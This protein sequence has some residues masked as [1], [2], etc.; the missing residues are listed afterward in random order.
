MAKLG[1][2]NIGGRMV[3]A[4]LLNLT[5]EE[6]DGLKWHSNRNLLYNWYFGNPVNQRGQTLYPS[7]TKTQYTIDG[8]LSLS[9]YVE[10]KIMDG[11]IQLTETTG[12]QGTTHFFEQRT[13]QTFIGKKTLS[14][15]LNDGTL[16]WLS[17]SSD[18]II[19][20]VVD[21]KPFYLVWVN[22]DHLVRLSGAAGATIAIK[23][24]KLELGSTQT[25]AHQDED[26]NWVLNEIPDY[27][28]ELAKCQRYL[29]RLDAELAIRAS[30][31]NQNGMWFCVSTPVSMRAIPT[32][33]GTVA[34]RD[35]E[36]SGVSDS[37]FN[38]FASN[39]LSNYIFVTAQKSNNTLTD[40]VMYVLQEAYFSAEL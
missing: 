13:E 23:A 29:L 9:W 20:F 7:A 26:G 25:L 36:G 1:E 33:V 38:F 16:Y 10:T 15:M 30:Y 21:G 8:W 6:L 3:P 12:T 18:I 11:C 19:D 39:L 28:E 31:A 4:W 35:V 14:I 34:V 2:A 22:S 37:T 27:G 40:G 24:V 17:G 32:I 5:A